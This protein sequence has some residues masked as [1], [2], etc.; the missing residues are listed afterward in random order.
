MQ[1][2]KRRKDFT[3]LTQQMSKKGIK[4]RTWCKAKKLSNADYTILLNM[5]FGK[6]KGIRGRAKELREILEKDGFE[7]A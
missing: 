4:L 2:K 5:S 3:S 7:V 1:N 6:T